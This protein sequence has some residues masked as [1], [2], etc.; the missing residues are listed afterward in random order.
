MATPTCAFWKTRGD[1]TKARP[2]Q[3]GCRSGQRRACQHRLES[4]RRARVMHD[5]PT[6]AT[7]ERTGLDQP[8]GPG[9]PAVGLTGKG[10]GVA[11]IDS[12][13]SEFA[14]RPVSELAL[15][16]LALRTAGR[17]FQGLHSQR[18]ET[19]VAQR[20]LSTTTVMAHT[21]RASSRAPVTTRTV[22]TRAS[23]RERSWLD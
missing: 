20:P 3:P 4:A 1:G 12:G 6:F 11:V 8:G 5:R 18:P 16:L 15:E 2:E 23:R 21:S 19:V 14:R 9:A 22:S 13:I 10:V 17:A 7:L